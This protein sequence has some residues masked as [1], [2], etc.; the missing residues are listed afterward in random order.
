MIKSHWNDDILTP[1]EK[2][3]EIIKGLLNEIAYKFSKDEIDDSDDI[4]YDMTERQKKLVIGFIEKE[5]ERI[6]RRCNL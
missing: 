2:A 5:T 1:R 3:K 6:I 4:F